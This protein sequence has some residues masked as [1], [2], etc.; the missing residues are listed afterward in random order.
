MLSVPVPVAIYFLV[1]TGVYKDAQHKP[2]L[3]LIGGL[4][5]T[6]YV[7]GL[8]ILRRKD[9]SK[10]FQDI[11]A[12]EMGRLNQKGKVALVRKLHVYPLREAF[13]AAF[14]WFTGLALMHLI[15]SLLEESSSQSL[16][17]IPILLL[18]VVPTSVIIFY[19]TTESVFERIHILPLIR[20]ILI[21]PG[22]IPQIGLYSR[23]LISFSTLV[24]VPITY[25]SY[26]V[27]AIQTGLDSGETLLL[28]I[29]SMGV[30]FLIPVL[31]V[32]HRIAKND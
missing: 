2:A 1:F 27:Y 28:H 12:L 22:K 14:R 23:I 24:L 6:I 32:S 11:Q 5:A 4:M 26:C 20:T 10:I 16:I 3:I 13:L 30:L 19:L 29:S 15:A 17:S 21:P 8:M 9:L 18:L 7:L 31:L 25:A